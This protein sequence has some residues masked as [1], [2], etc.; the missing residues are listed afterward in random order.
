[1]Q[2]LR[3]ELRRQLL[4]ALACGR[5]RVAAGEDHVV[6]GGSYVQAAAAHYDGHGL[7]REHAV[8][9]RARLLLIE[10]D[11]VVVTGIRDVDAVMRDAPL[12]DRQLGGPDVHAAVD[13]HR[14]GRHD[15]ATQPDREVLAQ[16]RL[17]HTGRPD[18]GDDRPRQC[19]L[20]R[21]RHADR[22]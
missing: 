12:P 6:Q 21:P 8:D 14:V 11:G 22:P 4:V 20:A 15:L 9:R 19:V 1:V 7:P 16:G 17:A 2:A 18:D 13:L 3:A 10:G 5:G